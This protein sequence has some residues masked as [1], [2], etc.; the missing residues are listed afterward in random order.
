[1][2]KRTSSPRNSCT[3]TSRPGPAPEARTRRRRSRG[4]RA[5]RT[6]HQTIAGTSHCAVMCRWLLDWEI[7]PGPKPQKPR[8]RRRR[9]G[10]RRASGRTAGTRRARWPP[11]CRTVSTANVT[12]APKVSVT[13]ASSTPSVMSRG[14]DHQVHPVRGVEPVGDQAELTEQHPGV[15]GQEPLDQGLVLRV[16]GQHTCGRV[17][18]Q[19]VTDPGGDREKAQPD[20][21][22]PQVRPAAL[23]S[24][25]PSGV[26]VG[27]RRASPI[28]RT[29]KTIVRR[30]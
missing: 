22:V 17:R 26:P 21:Y 13:G 24:R 1:M 29:A 25:L 7:M 14:V 2:R 10:R 8:R 3:T 27:P 9:P 5:S 6:T 28:I 20:A 15:D 12:G 18:P 19:P 11:G 23:S 16:E 30:L 4:G